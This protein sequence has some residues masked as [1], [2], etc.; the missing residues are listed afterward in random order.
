MYIFK[1]FPGA[2]PRTPLESF[3]CFKQ[4]QISSAEKTTLKKCVEI[5]HP[6]LFKISRYATA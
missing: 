2:C 6:P 5:M 4:L 1:K 3:L